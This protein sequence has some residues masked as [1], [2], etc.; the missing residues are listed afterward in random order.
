M[1]NSVGGRLLLWCV[2]VAVDAGSSALCEPGLDPAWVLQSERREAVI[3]Q[4]QTWLMKWG[5]VGKAVELFKGTRSWDLPYTWRMYHTLTGERNT[6]TV[7][8]EFEDLAT[9]DRF[10]G[11]CHFKARMPA[12]LEKWRELEHVRYS[13]EFLTLEE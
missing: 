5:N 12:F 10:L 2:Q 8:T 7:E 4:R 13:V 3:V 6:F 9:H 1:R 11:R